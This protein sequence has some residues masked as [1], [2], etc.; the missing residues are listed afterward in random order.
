MDNVLKSKALR[1]F[2]NENKAPFRIN[3]ITVLI[4]KFLLT[5]VENGYVF[6]I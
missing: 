4:K 1:N 3:F 2:R 5:D 6:T